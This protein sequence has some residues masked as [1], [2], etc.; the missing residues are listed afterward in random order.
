MTLNCEQKGSKIHTN[1]LIRGDMADVAPLLDQQSFRLIYLDP[2]FL[3]GRQQVGSKA[4]MV[5]DDRW[6]GNLDSYLPWLKTRLQMIHSLLL[7]DGSLVLHLD[8]RASHYAKV[9][10]DEIF[11]RQGFINEIIWHYT[12]GGRSKRRFSCKHDTLLWY[13][14]STKP[15]FNIDA[16]RVPYKPTSGYAKGG[17]IS[18]GGRKYMPDPRGTP[19]DDVWDI[20]IINPLA[21]E[22]VGYPTQKPLIL[23][24]RLIEALSQPGDLVGDFC[25]GSGT[26]LV[27]AQTLQRRWVGCDV[28]PIATACAQDRLNKECGLVVNVESI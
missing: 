23:L 17:I 18:A 8:Y 4:A 11:G 24:N 15:V 16:V 3:T 19:V 12:G 27:S 26:T 10:L 13:S 6:E 28:S 1:R 20:P 14:R 22:R 7:P 5:Y 2:P 9:M 25:C 21:N